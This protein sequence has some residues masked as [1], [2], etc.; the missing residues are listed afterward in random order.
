MSL[1]RSRQ[2]LRRFRQGCNHSRKRNRI[3]RNCNRLRHRSTWNLFH[4]RG[5]RNRFRRQHTSTHHGVR[6]PRPMRPRRRGRHR[7]LDSIAADERVLRRLRTMNDTTPPP[8]TP[9]ETFISHLVE[10]RS[11][12]LRAIIAVVVVLLCLFPFAK[13]IYAVLAAPLL[14]ALPAGATM[15]AT[16]VTGTF[17]VPL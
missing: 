16:D 7:C 8:E 13:D 15:I 14:K 2:R 11:R 5:T 1:P 10:L 6:H 4:H 12:L 3:R 17:L 9:Q